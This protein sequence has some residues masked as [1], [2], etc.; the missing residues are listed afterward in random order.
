MIRL[1]KVVVFWKCTSKQWVDFFSLL[2]S[3]IL[4]PRLSADQIILERELTERD[5]AT[6]EAVGQGVGSPAKSDLPA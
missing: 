5:C 1:R 3:L 6:L 4:P 2:I